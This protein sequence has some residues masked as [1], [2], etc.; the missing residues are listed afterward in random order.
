MQ[1]TDSNAKTRKRMLHLFR[2]SEQRLDPL[3]LR[4]DLF[5]DVIDTGLEPL[6][7]RLLPDDCFPDV[8]QLVDHARTEVGSQ[9]HERSTTPD[10]SNDEGPPATKVFDYTCPE[11]RYGLVVHRHAQFAVV[12]CEL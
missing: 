3:T 1:Q 12:I 4:A 9:R 2:S 7:A 8:L 5:V 6:D 11:I 10:K